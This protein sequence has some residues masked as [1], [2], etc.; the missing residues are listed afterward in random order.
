M[1]PPGCYYVELERRIRCP[2]TVHHPP[3][4]PQM[5][6]KPLKPP[7]PALPTSSTSPLVPFTLLPLW[8][9]QISPQPSLPQSDNPRLPVYPSP[10]LPVCSQPRLEL[11]APFPRCSCVVVWLAG[12]CF[13]V[14]SPR[15]PNSAPISLG[16]LHYISRSAASALCV[17]RRACRE[18]LQV[19]PSAA[20]LRHWFPVCRTLND[21]QAE[22]G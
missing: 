6:C 4:R 18:A 19:L 21:N 20:S 3:G 15:P 5:P 14:I 17:H 2:G 11:H 16:L 8:P 22:T 13:F 7:N 12:A 1:D 10:V 9:R